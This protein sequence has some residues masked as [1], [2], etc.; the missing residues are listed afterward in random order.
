MESADPVNEPL[1][2]CYSLLARGVTGLPVK[3]STLAT[4][5]GCLEQPEYQS[6]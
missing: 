6:T 4:G 2:N 1:A 3:P 5:M